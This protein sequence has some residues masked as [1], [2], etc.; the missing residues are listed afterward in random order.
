MRNPNHNL[1][2]RYDFPTDANYVAY[3]N[4]A[5]SIAPTKQ[6]WMSVRPHHLI[7]LIPPNHFH[8]PFRKFAVALVPRMHL[9]R[10]GVE[11]MIQRTLTPSS[12]QRPLTSCLLGFGVDCTLL[13]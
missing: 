8:S 1:A 9:I 7:Y 11:A 12:Y 10:A 3:V 2:F 13:L 4:Y 6:T 5:K